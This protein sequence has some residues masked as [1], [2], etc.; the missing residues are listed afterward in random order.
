[1]HGEILKNDTR[2]PKYPRYGKTSHSRVT[3]VLPSFQI[4]QGLPEN[5]KIYFKRIKIDRVR[6]KTVKTRFTRGSTLGACAVQ[7]KGFQYN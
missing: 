1:M 7:N 2:V 4:F 6:A 3:E 5:I